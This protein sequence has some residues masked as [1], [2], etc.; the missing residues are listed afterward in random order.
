MVKISFQ[1]YLKYYSPPT[2]IYV[3]IYS[4]IS[5]AVLS[6]CCSFNHNKLDVYFYDQKQCHVKSDSFYFHLF[7]KSLWCF[8]KKKAEFS[9]SKSL[10]DFTSSF[11][12]AVRLPGFVYKVLSTA[13]NKS[14]FFVFRGRTN[15]RMRRYS[16][17]LV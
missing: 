9:L 5:H 7:A 10:C 14:A 3:S 1:I 13:F 15:Y 17:Q 4:V 6:Y 16:P 12:S 8:F 11:L 2:I